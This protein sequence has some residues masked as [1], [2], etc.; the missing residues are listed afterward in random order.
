MSKLK[1]NYKHT[2]AQQE[3]FLYYI[4]LGYTEKEADLICSLTF[5]EEVPLGRKLFSGGRANGLSGAGGPRFLAKAYR[6]PANE[7]V[8]DAAGFVL[9]EP[10]AVMG[11]EAPA[12]PRRPA[13]IDDVRTDSYEAFE[14]SRIKSVHVSPTATFRTTN[15][16]AAAAV[17]LGNYFNG[18]NIFGNMAKTEEM[19]NFLSFDLKAPGRGGTDGAET[20]AFELTY[21][22]SREGDKGFLFLGI[23]G[24]HT[25]LKKQNIVLLIDT[26]GSMV[27]KKLQIRLTLATVFANLKEGDRISVITYSGEDHLFVNGLK[28][29]D[30]HGIEYLLKA[31]E[32]ME[33]S[34]C[35]NGSKGI[36]TAYDI[37]VENFIEDGI[38]R[39]IMVTDGDLNF[40]ITEKG[41]LSELITAKKQSGV[42]YS[43]IGTG[44]YNLMDDKLQALARNGNGN[45]FVI[46]SIKDAEHILR[47]RYEAL[48]AA[49]AKNVKVQVEFNPAAVKR[50]RLLGYETRGLSH[51]DFA[52]DAV[53]AEPFGSGDKAVACFE[54]YFTDDEV[55]PL[56][57]SAKAETSCADELCTVSL[58]YEHTDSKEVSELSWAVPAAAAAEI[59]ETDNIRKARACAEAAHVIMSEKDRG[60]VRRA[61]RSFAVLSGYL[62]E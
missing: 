28:K 22:L 47:D 41:K 38:N 61:L 5:E 10:E 32:K 52:N 30:A 16:A 33:I 25:E 46:N 35:T 44:L 50:Y 17:L 23:Q 21:E 45:Y 9:A 53:T 15:N 24:R 8:E 27:T 18:T 13:D 62:E 7:S 54:L 39:V 12:F 40:G 4:S 2:E 48:A 57:Y 60:L 59:P 36:E 19:M 3:E 55:K 58:R 11:A 51:E 43:A 49:I 56:K 31:L 6:A 34:G 14:E 1:N 26:S 29:S 20:E 42:Y 37:A